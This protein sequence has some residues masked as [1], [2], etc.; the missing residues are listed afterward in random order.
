M[1]TKEKLHEI[2]KKVFLEEFGV[3][4]SS[5]E[6]VAY[7]EWLGWNEAE[8]SEVYEFLKKAINLMR[9]YYG[10]NFFSYTPKG[11]DKCRIAELHG[12]WKVLEGEKVTVDELID[13]I[14]LVVR[15][16]WKAEMAKWVIKNQKPER[17]VGI[18]VIKGTSGEVSEE[19]YE[20]IKEIL[21]EKG[22][23]YESEE[24]LRELVNECLW[25]NFFEFE[26]VKGV[27][28][29]YENLVYGLVGIV[30]TE[31][32][33]WEKVRGEVKKVIEKILKKCFAERMNLN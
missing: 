4:I 27:E 5:P 33:S 6:W 21:E 2:V 8:E 13:L 10:D 16:E 17:Y 31:A 15:R 24:E 14:D 1:L 19:A 11:L 29:L 32:R 26:N 3:P 22:V 25:E 28:V 20:V 18:F 23:K 30:Y 7:L 9:K 12:V